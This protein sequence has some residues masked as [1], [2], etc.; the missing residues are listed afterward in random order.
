[1]LAFETY[2]DVV[3]VIIVIIMVVVALSLS[4]VLLHH[5]V[6]HSCFLHSAGTPNKCVGLLS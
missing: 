4:R 1:M 5:D 6:F 2:L 3:V